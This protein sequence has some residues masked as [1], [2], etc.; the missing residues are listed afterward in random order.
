MFAQAPSWSQLVAMAP[1][2]SRELVAIDGY[3]VDMDRLSPIEIPTLMM[4]GEVSP[5]WLIKVSQT[6]HDAL[7][8][9]SWATLAGQ[10]HVANETAPD[11]LAREVA[12]FVALLRSLAR[13]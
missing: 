11:L 8:R 10:G 13:P 2:W 1:T 4:A 6:V 3:A 5:S 12:S 9:C 7:P